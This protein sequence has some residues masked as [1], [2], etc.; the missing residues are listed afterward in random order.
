[1]TLEHYPAMTE[2]AL[3]AIAAEAEQR[4]PIVS[5][6]IIHRIGR[7]QAGARIV[8]VAVASRHRPAA[9]DACAFLLD[10]LKTSAPFWKLEE[11][12]AGARRRVGALG[13][14]AAP[15]QQWAPH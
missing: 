12:G 14:K 2:A 1:M 7:L 3:A 6:T 9:L 13:A 15:G 4:W 10:W 11:F 5:G 8:L